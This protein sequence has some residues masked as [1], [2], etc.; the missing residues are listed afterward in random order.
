MGN[1]IPIGKRGVVYMPKKVL[2][3]YELSEWD[4]VEISETEKGILLNPKAVVDKEYA[5]FFK[6]TKKLS[7]RPAT[8]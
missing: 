1:I 2:K 7:H 6:K 4:Y 3:K 5:W 8:I